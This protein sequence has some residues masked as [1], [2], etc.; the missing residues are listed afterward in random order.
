MG[1]D[2]E[3]QEEAYRAQLRAMTTA[4]QEAEQRRSQVRSQDPEDRRAADRA[5]KDEMARITAA[6]QAWLRAH[7][8]AA[9]QP[10]ERHQPRSR[11]AGSME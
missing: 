3:A 2:Q 1:R 8:P 11:W 5:F 7:L 9:D 4:R 6:H 10:G